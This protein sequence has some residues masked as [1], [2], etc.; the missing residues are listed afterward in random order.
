[1]PEDAFTG[2][3][4]PAAG[5]RGAHLAGH[6]GAPGAKASAA[7]LGRAAGRRA[8]ATERD[9]ARPGP[10]RGGLPRVAC[11]DRC[12]RQLRRR[13]R[14]VHGAPAGLL[15]RVRGEQRADDRQ[16]H[17]PRA[18]RD[19]ER[20]T[21]DDQADR[22]AHRAASGGRAAGALCIRPDLTDAHGTR[23]PPADR[24]RRRW[25]EGRARRSRKA[26]ADPTLAAPRGDHPGDGDLRGDPARRVS[27]SPTT[28]RDRDR[29]LRGDERRS[30]TR[31]VAGARNDTQLCRLLE[32]ASRRTATPRT[33]ASREAACRAES[34]PFI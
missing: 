6:P 25:H 5:R 27:R 7:C 15:L 19:A 22:L 29:L 16:A 1:M 31:N 8:R 9:R 24:R 33:G 12:S 21:T 2:L 34:A 28:D 30:D 4:S 10:A 13:A 18:R 14:A 17:L 23:A 20:A 3:L 26:P 11:R 32:R